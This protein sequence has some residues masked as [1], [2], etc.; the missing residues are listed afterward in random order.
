MLF[1]TFNVLYFYISTFR[2][3]C[4]VPNMAVFL[5]S[6]IRGFPMCCSGIFWMIL[7]WS[8]LPL[9]LLVLPLFLHPLCAMFL[10]SGLHTYNSES[11]W[12][13]SWSLSCFLKLLHLSA[14]MPFFYYHRSWHSVYCYGRFC[15]FSLV[16]LII[17][18][19][20][21]VVA[22]AAAAA[23]AATAATAVCFWP[24]S[25]LCV[26]GRSRPLRRNETKESIS[27][28]PMWWSC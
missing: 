11:N 7:R 17:I 1:P 18:I 26:S 8:Q 27:T 20:I 3:M 25:C 28:W 16:D 6:M 14:Y 21:I 10:L 12:L 4:A 15:L 5:S 19:I 13:L 9:L 2:S 22:A 24:F 23:A